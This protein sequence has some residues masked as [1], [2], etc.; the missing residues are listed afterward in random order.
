MD[1]IEQVQEKNQFRW[2]KDLLTRTSITRYVKNLQQSV[3]T[4]LYKLPQSEYHL[5]L[6]DLGGQVVYMSLVR[7]P[8]SRF[9]SA[10]NFHR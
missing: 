4:R 9:V 2:V 7:D 5:D 10:Y 8:V 3:R 6:R 1:L